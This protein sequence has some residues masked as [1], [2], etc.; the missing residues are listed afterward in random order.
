MLPCSCGTTPLFH[1]G[2]RGL[3][4]Q[5]VVAA[6]PAVSEAWGVDSWLVGCSHDRWPPGG[7]LASPWLPGPGVQLAAAGRKSVLPSLEPGM[8]QAGPPTYG[9][10]STMQREGLWHLPADEQTEISGACGASL[11]RLAGSS[12][13][14]C[15]SGSSPHPAC[16]A[17]WTHRPTSDLCSSPPSFP[18]GRGPGGTPGGTTWP[19]TSLL[20]LAFCW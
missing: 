10:I 1:L 6:R 14:T 17:G 3:Q 9:H 16:G 8:A 19:L 11:E 13:V 5:G 4:S 7:R 20:H 12:Q 15:K 2:T 18:M